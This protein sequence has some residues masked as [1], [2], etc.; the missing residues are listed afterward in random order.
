MASEIRECHQ[1][2]QAAAAAAASA[3]MR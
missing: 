2:A 3:V 1:L